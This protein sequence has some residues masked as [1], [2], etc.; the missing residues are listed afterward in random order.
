[1]R[2]L[3]DAD[4]LS[5]RTLQRVTS[6]ASAGEFEKAVELLIRS[7]RA[8]AEPVTV[9]ERDELRAVLEAMNMPAEHIDALA[10]Q[11]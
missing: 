1:M 2:Y 3:P 6:E 4:R 10:V 9:Q 7:L 5:S 11:R 8:R